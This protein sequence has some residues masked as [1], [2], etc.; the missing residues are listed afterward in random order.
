[1]NLANSSSRIIIIDGFSG[2]FANSINIVIEFHFS[3]SFSITGKSV[4]AFYIRKW[5]GF[6]LSKQIKLPSPLRFRLHFVCNDQIA[7]ISDEYPSI[8]MKIIH[9]NL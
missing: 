2:A 6:S 7:L 4:G 3:I 5:S 1:M 8:E 9:L